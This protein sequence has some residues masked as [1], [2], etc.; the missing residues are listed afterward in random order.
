MF[1][2]GLGPR[3]ELRGLLWNAAETPRNQCWEHQAKLSSSFCFTQTV[4]RSSP[5]SSAV[6]SPVFVP[7]LCSRAVVSQGW[8]PGQGSPAAVPAAGVCARHE[9]N[10]SSPSFHVGADFAVLTQLITVCGLSKMKIVLFGIF[11]GLLQQSLGSCLWK[12]RI[13]IIYL[14]TIYV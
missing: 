8:D 3:A 5:C 4:F 6:M 10:S 7:L 14:S 9:Q 12:I 11:P 2:T 13:C 1:Y